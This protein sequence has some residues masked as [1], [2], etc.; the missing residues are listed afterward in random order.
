MLFV[1]AII[2]PTEGILIST[3]LLVKSMGLTNSLLGLILPGLIGPLNVLLMTNAFRSVPQELIEAA[4]VDGA[5]MWQRFFH[6]AA[7]QVK[8]TMTVIG[9]L[10][11]VG[12]YNDFLW[13][14]VVL[15]DDREYT[16]TLGLNRLQ[17]TF[18]TDP[19]LVAAGAIISL[20]PI[21][22]FFALFQKNLFLGL[23]EGGLK[24]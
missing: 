13:P 14:L 4:K 18:Y 15:S 8:G 5:N 20:V 22:I 6:I 7:P 24:G 3:F 16:L 11:F 23:Q 17:G 9:I 10:S 12:S 21:V 2:M 1:L 19:R